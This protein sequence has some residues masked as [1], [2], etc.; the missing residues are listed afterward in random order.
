MKDENELNEVLVQLLIGPT[1]DESH[2]APLKDVRSYEDLY[3]LFVRM[4]QEAAVANRKKL[5]Q[6]NT[7]KPQNP[8]NPEIWLKTTDVM[9]YCQISRRTV[10]NY[11]EQK[12]LAFTKLKKDCFYRQCDVDAMMFNKYNGKQVETNPTVKEVEH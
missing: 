5:A 2:Y 4:D 8:I 6:I 11:R 3:R 1:R 10:A 12:K 7:K 9:S